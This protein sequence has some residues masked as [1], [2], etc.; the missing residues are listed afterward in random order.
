MPSL[1]SPSDWKSH[2]VLT[3]DGY[4]RLQTDDTGDVEVRLFL[5]KTLLQEAELTLYRQII[6]AT[7]FPG[8]KLVAI[9]PDV[10]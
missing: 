4:Y 7:R 8:C 6:N 5:T 9:T 1:T 2:A 10:H 3:D